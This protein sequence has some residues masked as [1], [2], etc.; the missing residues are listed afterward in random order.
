MSV[1]SCY[2]LTYPPPIARGQTN[3]VYQSGPKLRAVIQAKLLTLVILLIQICERHLIL[4]VKVIRYI[5]YKTQHTR[6]T[7]T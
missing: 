1:H 3:A 7:Q 4:L 2:S 6:C 5:F